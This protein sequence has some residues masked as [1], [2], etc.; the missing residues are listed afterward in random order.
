LFVL[1]ILVSR[2][3]GREPTYPEDRYW[4]AE[5]TALGG[6][7]LP[8]TED[9][10]MTLMT[11]PAG[12]ATHERFEVEPSI[13]L[14]TPI[15]TIAG[16]PGLK[17]GSLSLPGFKSDI[18]AQPGNM[19][20]YGGNI[21]PAIA[22]KGFSFGVMASERFKAV[23]DGTT[24]DTQYVSQTIPTLGFGIPLARGII[25]LG[26]SIQYVN[27]TVATNS[28]ALSNISTQNFSQN[29]QEGA[30]FSHTAAV[31]IVLPYTYRPALYLVARNIFGMA[32]SGAPLIGGGIN[33]TTLAREPMTADASFSITPRIGDTVS[34]RWILEF[35]DLWFA[36]RTSLMDHVSAGG[37]MTFAKMY[38]LRLGFN[39]DQLDFGFGFRLGDNNIDLSLFK[40]RNDLPLGGEFDTKL[41]VQYTFHF[42]TGPTH[43][44]PEGEQR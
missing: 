30:G 20:G 38:A 40:E 10:G 24:V 29:A 15:S 39:A 37:E 5:S 35:R 2:A 25:R 32:Y 31:G 14:E 43:T 34:S 6:A 4:D 12:L 22:W 41:M 36:Q 33:S 11:N 17:F 18:A 21:L 19:L 28:F 16:Y 1:V 3:E 26:Y 9:L 13:S 27:T 8:L 44:I 7:S 42:K 23:T